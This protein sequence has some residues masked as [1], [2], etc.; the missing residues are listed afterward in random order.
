MHMSLFKT[1]SNR[2]VLGDGLQKSPFGILNMH[3]KFPNVPRH[4]LEEVGYVGEDIIKLCKQITY[5]YY[6]HGNVQFVEG[7]V[8]SRLGCPR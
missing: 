8:L 1:L 4:T 2:R 5:R 3:L 6:I 7:A